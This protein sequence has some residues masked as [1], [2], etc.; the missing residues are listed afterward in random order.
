MKRIAKILVILAALAMLCGCTEVPENNT[1]E[2][3]ETPSNTPSVSVPAPTDPTNKQ[4]GKVTYTVTVVDQ[5][6]NPVAGVSIQFCDDEACKLPVAT[7][8]DGV[9][10][11]K[12]PASNYHITIAELPAGYTCEETEFYF[13]DGNELTVT[14]TAAG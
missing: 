3:A 11:A 7:N 13:E 2:P 14:V 12:Y 5:N 1:S 9:V 4:D 8:S 6:G 10:T